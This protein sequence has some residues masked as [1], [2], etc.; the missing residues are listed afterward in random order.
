MPKDSGNAPRFPEFGALFEHVIKLLKYALPPAVVL[1]EQA[2]SLG[3]RELGPGEQ[4]QKFLGQFG[5]GR[6][7]HD[8]LWCV[9]A[10][11]TIEALAHRRTD[12]ADILLIMLAI[13]YSRQQAQTTRLKSES[14]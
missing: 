4:D 6:W 13:C 12:F 8:S 1:V 10:G 7:G 5:G 3:A 2:A 11:M 14:R 9:R